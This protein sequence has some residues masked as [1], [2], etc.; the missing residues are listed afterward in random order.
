MIYFCLSDTDTSIGHC[1]LFPYTCLFPTHRIAIWRSE[2][3]K[4]RLLNFKWYVAAMFADRELYQHSTCIALSARLSLSGCMVSQSFVSVWAHKILLKLNAV[5]YFFLVRFFVREHLS[6][7]F[8]CDHIVS[9]C[10][11]HGSVFILLFLRSQTSKGLIRFQLWACFNYLSLF[12]KYEVFRDLDLQW[13]S[14]WFVYKNMYIGRESH[15]IFLCHIII[16]DIYR[17]IFW[18]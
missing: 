12:W 18:N 8:I 7:L 9:W 1:Q 2:M 3:A 4:T 6:L 11:L 17:L 14:S 5:G 10:S 16:S 15:Y 13:I